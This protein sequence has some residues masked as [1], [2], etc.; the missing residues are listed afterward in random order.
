[1]CPQASTKNKFDILINSGDRTSGSP[2]RSTFSCS[3]TGFSTNLSKFVNHHTCYV[4]LNYFGIDASASTLTASN[5]NLHTLRFNV[6][7]ASLP[8]SFRTNEISNNNCSNLLAT[9]TIGLVPISSSNATY[10]NDDF[11]NQYVVSSNIFSGDTSITLL[12][13]NGTELSLSGR[14][15]T[16]QLCVYFDDD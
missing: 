9:N 8:H 4:K 13:Q 6:D 11:D 1:M 7:S 5:T 12:N 14:T 10:S 2:S 3:S 15:W 16:A